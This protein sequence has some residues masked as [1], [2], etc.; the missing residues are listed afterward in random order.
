MGRARDSRGSAEGTAWHVLV[1]LAALA[2]GATGGRA[3]TV[4]SAGNNGLPIEI[5]AD[6]LEVKQD[7]KTAVFRGSVAA[8][9]GTLRLT[10]DEITVHYGQVKGSAPARISRID[11]AGNVFVSSPEE[12]AQG[13]RGVYDVDAESITL[14]GSVVLTRD[15]NVIR[16]SRLVLNLATGKSRIEGT[17]ADGAQG[18]VRGRFVPGQKQSE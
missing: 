9:Q 18:R 1:V 5:T 11:A 6:S 16:G 12:T 13:D 17:P 3:Q 7:Q 14:T 15:E 2:V 4:P 10:A 8:A